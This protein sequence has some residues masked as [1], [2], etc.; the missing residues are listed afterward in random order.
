MPGSLHVG[1]IAGIKIYINYS[2]LII[3]VLLTVSLAISWFPFSTPGLA[4][5]VYYVLGFIA[6][7]LLFVS[8]L[9][10]ELAHSLVARARGLAPQR[11]RGG[12]SPPPC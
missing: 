10:H 6:A 2:W 1:T 9:V 11:K 8:V 7:I 4:T 12:A 5:G 3:L